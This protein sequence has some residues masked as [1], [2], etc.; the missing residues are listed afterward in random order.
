[1]IVIPVYNIILAPETNIYFGIDQL[2]R[3][4]GVKGLTVGDIVVLAAT[5]ENEN[6]K[7]MTP[8]SF[9]PIGMAGYVKEINNQGYIVIHTEYRVDISDV[10]IDYD[11]SI[12]LSMVR[13]N[14]INDMSEAV[15]A[16]KLKK[17]GSE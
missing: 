3:S 17:L 11:H 13:R 12:R 16:E 14:D 9:Y 8:S 15:E 1:M 7:E 2:R 5:R 10:E 4:T 6:Y